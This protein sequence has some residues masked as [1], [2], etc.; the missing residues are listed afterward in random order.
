MEHVF[1][2]GATGFLGA[3]LVRAILESSAAVLYLLVR[4]S[5]ECTADDRIKNLLMELF[6]KEQNPEYLPRVH[7]VK[8]D[9]GRENLGLSAAAWN[10]LS[11]KIDTIFHS[12]ATIHLN[13]PYEEASEINLNGTKRVLA[14]AAKCRENKVLQRFNHIS[15][16][17][18]AGKTKRFLETD[19][20]I[21][22]EFSNSYEQTKLESELEVL[23]YSAKGLPVMIFRPSII[24]GNYKTGE[25]AKSSIT[26]FIVRRILQG[27]FPDFICNDDSE[28]NIVPVD[29]VVDAMLH[30]T[31]SAAN[32]GKAFNLTNKKN[33][34][35]KQMIIST[36]RLLNREPVKIYAI[37]D[38]KEASEPT[39]KALAKFLDY[40]SIC[41]T[42]DDTL[43]A[44]ALQGSGINCPVIDNDFSAKL[45]ERVKNRE[46]REFEV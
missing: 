5:E 9:I 19:F 31:K 17:Y 26:F 36:C 42:F 40:L 39:R 23:K 6:P 3:N 44:E 22:Q 37:E 28:L 46:F 38:A 33:R 20:D 21:G 16:A 2:T 27:K 7:A 41:H 34:N 29:Y 43:A 32:L 30:I 10:E 35:I 1:I 8:G 25:A 24:T 45:L 14:L 13:L 4:E 11:Q 15:S 18:V 12:A